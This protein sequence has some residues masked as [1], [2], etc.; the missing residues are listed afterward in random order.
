MVDAG[1]VGY[2]VSATRGTAEAAGAIGA[3]VAL[4]IRTYVREET[5]RLYGFSRRQERDA[6]DLLLTIPGVGPSLCLA[7]LSDLAIGELVQA[8]VA[9]D[10]KRLTSVKGIGKK[11]AEKILLELKSKNKMEALAACL[12][13]QEHRD[14][15]AAPILAG[16]AALDAV[17]ALEA[18][19]VT[20]TQAR[21][22]I[23]KALEILGADAPT[24]ALVREGLRHRRTI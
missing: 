21:K 16:S 20:P 23:A 8:V 17:A 4:W 5:L 13:P 10:A 3:E 19:D 15:L 12:T 2:G 9:G 6:F 24:E 1:G 11:V 7:I 14:A 22:A 18:L